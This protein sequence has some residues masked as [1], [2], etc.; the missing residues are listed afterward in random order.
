MPLKKRESRWFPIGTLAIVYLLPRLEARNSSEGGFRL[1]GRPT[2]K[3]PGLAV[4]PRGG[5]R[6]SSEVGSLLATH[7]ETGT[8]VRF[9]PATGIFCADPNP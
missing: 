3:V 7:L 4:I 8:R 1:A 5:E 9:P 2:S 6:V